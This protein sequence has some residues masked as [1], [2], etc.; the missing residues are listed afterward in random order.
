MSSPIGRNDFFCC[1]QFTANND[2]IVSLNISNI[3]KHCQDTVDEELD[4]GRDFCNVWTRVKWSD[5]LY[6]AK[7]SEEL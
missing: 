4:W 1:S 5:N 2:N 6:S 7:K 3:F